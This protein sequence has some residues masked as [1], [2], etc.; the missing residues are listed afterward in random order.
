MKTR[1]VQTRLWASITIMMLVSACSLPFFSGEKSP[2]EAKPTD[3]QQTDTE[4]IANPQETTENEQVE[5]I[6]P[7]PLIGLTELPAYLA[8]FRQDMV[9]TL[10]G[11]P[12]ERHTYLLISRD[13]SS[14]NYDFMNLSSGTGLMD[15]QSRVLSLDQAFYR[16]TQPDP[17]CQGSDQAPAEGE[18]LEPA[19][20]LLPVMQADR[21]GRETVNEINCTHY[22]FTEDDLNGV[23][24]G[25][26]VAG[27]VW[28]ANQGGYVVKYSLV[29]TPPANSDAD[30]LSVTQTWSYDLSIPETSSAIVLPPNCQEV[31]LDLPLPTDAQ[32]IRRTGGHVSFDTGS[33]ARQVVDYYAAA[34]PDVGWVAPDT[35]PD[36][37]IELP[38]MASFTQAE[39]T[40][41]LVLDEAESNGIRV[42]I[43]IRIQQMSILPEGTQATA[44]TVSSGSGVPTPVATIDPSASGLPD[45]IPLYPGATDLFSMDTVTMFSSTDDIGLI[46]E[47]YKQA[48]ADNGW[49]LS[50]E[51]NAEG[52]QLQQWSKNGVEIFIT[53]SA[54]GGRVTVVITRI[55]E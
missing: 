5:G 34:L 37:E 43:F 44:T 14:D 4:N 22:Q 39:Q 26:L 8:G 53:M 11:E 45:D 24:N 18:V 23:E 27:D 42:D 30:D 50:L 52:T 29:V 35:L 3:E 32:D 28:I 20:L 12:Y 31:P 54:D 19:S 9:G 1:P 7:D 36:G 46:Q 48:M 49:S 40:L 10:K 17:S 47:Y 25:T 55:T 2:G 6:L 33:T 51:Q 41:D 16:W 15:Y 13:T 38:Y 21:L